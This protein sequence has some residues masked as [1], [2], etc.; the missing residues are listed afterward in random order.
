M[1]PF[2]SEEWGNPSSVYRFGVRAR[3]AVDQA[4]DRVAR[5]VG[6]QSDEVIFTSCATEANNTAIHSALAANPAKRHIVTTEV[7]HSSVLHFCEML[8]RRGYQVTFLPVDRAGHLDIATLEKAIRPDTAVVSIMWA[9]NETGVVSPVETISRICNQREVLYHCDAVQAVGKLPL[10]FTQLPVDY[11]T[12]S[13]HKIGAP[14][15][16]G[17]LITRRGVSVEPLIIGGQQEGGRRGGTESVPLIVA[18]GVAAEQS[19][20]RGTDAWVRVKAMRDALEKAVLESISGA[21]VNGDSP[22]LPNTLNFGVPGIDSTALVTYLDGQGVCVS[23]GS[24]CMESAQSPSHVILAMTRNHQQ[25]T[26]SIR[27]SLGYETR[28]EEIDAVA[29]ILITA[30]RLLRQ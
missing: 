14:K 22:R 17:A 6:A 18:M 16:I 30:V 12:I 11:L 13:G 20:V 7:E 24:A 2:L 19:S 28:P 29:T 15:G 26:E 25:A 23:S 1:G 5:L 27:I 10:C 21:Y 9:N 8:A 3:A 4:R